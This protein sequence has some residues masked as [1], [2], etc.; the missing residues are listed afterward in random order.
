[1]SK[2]KASRNH[3]STKRNFCFVNRRVLRISPVH[4]E[5]SLV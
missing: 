3:L 1:V 5:L 4:E 2:V